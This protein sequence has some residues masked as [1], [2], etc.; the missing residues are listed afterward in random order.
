VEPEGPGA[1]GATA[2]GLGVTWAAPEVDG[3][4]DFTFEVS[5]SDGHNPP[6]TQRLTVPVR[7]PSF[8]ADIQPLFDARCTHCHGQAAALELGAGHSHANLVGVPAYAGDC[9]RKLHLPRVKPGD[10]DGSVLI[11]RVSGEACGHRMPWDHPTWFDS[12][13][14]E[15]VRLRSWIRAGAPED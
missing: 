12:H 7:V 2:D 13:P 10:P 11:L 4:T 14:E 9:A 6:V 1:L 15:L 8:S 5:V 3:P